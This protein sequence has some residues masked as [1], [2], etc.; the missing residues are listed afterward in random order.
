MKIYIN[1]DYLTLFYYNKQTR[2]YPDGYF[3]LSLNLNELDS[4]A[5]QIP[6][7]ELVPSILEYYTNLPDDY[8][9]TYFSWVVYDQNNN[10]QELFLVSIHDVTAMA[11]IKDRL[12]VWLSN[13]KEEI[14]F[15]SDM[16]SSIENVY[17]NFIKS[18][19]GN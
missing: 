5:L 7:K 19:K 14:L 17:E 4:Y 10:V 8:K 12:F 13:A 9:E 2:V 11:L 18:L 6:A 1:Y 3:Y 15:N 16:F